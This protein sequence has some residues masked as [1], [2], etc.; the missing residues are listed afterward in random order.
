MEVFNLL[1]ALPTREVEDV[2]NFRQEVEIV[3]KKWSGKT[4][5]RKGGGGHPWA[6]VSNLKSSPGS[7]RG[8]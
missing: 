6:R 2:K 7:A 8:P 3:L 4:L 5:F 1:V